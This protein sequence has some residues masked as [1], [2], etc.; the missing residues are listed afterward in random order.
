VTALK[1]VK[2]GKDAKSSK[3][4]SEN[5]GVMKGKSGG[6]SSKKKY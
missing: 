3:V 4:Q 1:K 2:K 6:G 5:P